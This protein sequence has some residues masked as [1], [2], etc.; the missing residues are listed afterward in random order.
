MNQRPGKTH[1]AVLRDGDRIALRDL[2][3]FCKSAKE[4][5]EKEGDQDAAFRF[6]MLEEY[7]RTGYQGGKL[8]YKSNILGL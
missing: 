6:E 3:D 4:D 8:T 2:V 1:T 7:L 5:L